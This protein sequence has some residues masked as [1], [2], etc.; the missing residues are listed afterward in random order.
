[1]K[2]GRQVRL[3]PS[4]G[5]F[6]LWAFCG[7]VFAYLIFPILIVIPMSFSSAPYAI[8]PP[9]GLSLRWYNSYLGSYQWLRATALSFEVGALTALISI[10]LGTPA[11]FA[12]VRGRFAGKDLLNTF[13]ILPLVVPTI[14]VAIALYSLFADLYL[15][16]TVSGLVLAH[17]L[18]AAP[19]VVIIVSSTLKGDDR[20]LERAAMS[21]G[22]TPWRTFVHV[23]L[24]LVQQGV[25]SAAIIAFITSFDEVVIAIFITGS[26]AITLPRQMWDGVRTEIDPTIAAVS[27]LLVG[28]SIVVLGLVFLMARWVELSRERR[29]GQI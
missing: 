26:S 22:A 5:R 11:A 20:S 8:F 6:A 12:L 17:T 14:I 1:M 3:T 10:V 4:L 15:I 18:L 27:S 19:L 21:L 29:V 2:R 13:L 7:F 24:P 28:M 9:P 16:G 25:W 23:T